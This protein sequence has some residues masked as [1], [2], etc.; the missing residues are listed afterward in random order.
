MKRYRHYL[1]VMASGCFDPLH[2]GHLDYL[3]QA[4]ALG[5]RL[6]VVVEPDEA[7]AK[8]HRVLLPQAA[9]AEVLSA[10][11]C[12]DDVHLND[13]PASCSGLIRKH[14]PGMYVVGADHANLN[15]P[16]A[17]TCRELNIEVRAVGFRRFSS[18]A[19]VAGVQWDNPP[20]CASVLPVSQGRQVLL[21]RKMTGKLALIGGFVNKGET[22]EQAVVRECLEETGV[23]ISPTDLAYHSSFPGT[24]P[25][26][27]K[28][29]SVAFLCDQLPYPTAQ[30]DLAELEWVSD[31]PS[32]EFFTDADRA[33]VAAFFGGL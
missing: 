2:P 26:G 8:K 3:Q 21:G 29:L 15:F 12:V 20:V 18:S 9:R 30:D 7:V 23:R 10:L 28:I 24:Y 14:Q 19:L 31:M 17:D 11:R 22:L 16:E 4:R 1:A 32:D 25:D 27:R 33:A 13:D 6:L 5:D